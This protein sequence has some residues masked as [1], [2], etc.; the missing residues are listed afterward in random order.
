MPAV[1]SRAKR[2]IPVLLILAVAAALVAYYRYQRRPQ[3]LV[4][5]GTIEARTVN[6]GSL[7]GGRVVRVHVD[8]GMH[9]SAGAL[10]VTLETES[11]DR[12]L[13]EQQA[14]IEVAQA[15]L[16]RAIAGPR[17]EEIAQAAAIA[18]NDE[19]E[20]R[21][22]AA[23]FEAG[24]VARQLYE[25]AA[26]KAK[27]S[28]E[29]YKLLQR[30]TRKEDI[31]AARAAVE[32][33]RAHLATLEKQREESVVTSSVAGIVQ[34]FNLR[35]GDIV[36]AN[37]T[38]AEILEAGQLW[39]RVYVPETLL[40]LVRVNQPVKVKVDTFKD[41]TFAGRVVSVS[42]EGEYTPRNV[43]TRAQ[44][45]DQVFGVR[46]FVNPDPRLKP[47]MAAAVDLGV[48]GVRE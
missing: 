31:D 35:P 30:G 47:G 3:P 8:E 28:A 9:V 25:D 18:E 7:V 29:Q 19:R 27:T 11:I 33:A 43:Q 2:I 15:A 14:A 42:S 4:L 41:V 37:Q 38:V 48:E 32:Q 34:S 21:R 10:L 22:Q 13:A 39:V 17:Q 20:R 12:Q 45:A 6:A 44:R 1:R 23:L 5:S 46:V 40:G 16:D 36:A 26:T 24:I